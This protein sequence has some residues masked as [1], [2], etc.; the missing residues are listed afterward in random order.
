V[1]LGDTINS[2][3]WES[4][5]KVNPDG[6]GAF[7]ASTKNSLGKADLFRIEFPDARPIVVIAGKVINGKTNKRL[8]NG[9]QF[10]IVIND[11]VVDS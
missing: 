2:E 6:K 10:Q 9:L 5:Y 11:R 1:P 3:E 4:Y 8:V 7:F